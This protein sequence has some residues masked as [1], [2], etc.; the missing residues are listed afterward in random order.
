MLEVTVKVWG[1]M[2]TSS[3]KTPFICPSPS[4]LDAL[5]VS[6]FSFT[7]SAL[8]RVQL[9]T[10]TTPYSLLKRHV[11]ITLRYPDI[12]P[13]GRAASYRRRSSAAGSR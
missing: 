9:V 11:F 6:A 13:G 1:I 10:F 5:C 8:D 2:Q 7:D 4:S 12:L 3:V